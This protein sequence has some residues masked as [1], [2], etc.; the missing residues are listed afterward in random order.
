MLVKVGRRGTI[1]IPKD[2]RAGLQESS[3]VEV[4]RRPDGVIELR[5]QTIVDASQAW[6]WTERWQ[7]ME[8]D[9]D[10]DIKAGRVMS[11]NS[12]DELIAWLHAPDTGPRN[13]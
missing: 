10:E 11:F 7:A 5:P 3:L 4:V 1:T 12:P 2:L 8:R 6:Y 13:P 9:A